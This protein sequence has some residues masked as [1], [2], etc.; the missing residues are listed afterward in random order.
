MTVHLD[1]TIAKDA[2][3]DVVDWSTVDGTSI[4]Y[5][6]FMGDVMFVVGRAPRPASQPV[7]TEGPAGGAGVAV[8]ATGSG[9]GSERRKVREGFDAHGPWRR[10]RR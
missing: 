2:D 5:S 7:R 6:T 9:M 1:A 8:G 4:H 10:R 3:R